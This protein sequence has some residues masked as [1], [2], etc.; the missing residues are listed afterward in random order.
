[1]AVFYGSRHRFTRPIQV[2]D[3]DSNVY[4]VFPL[5]QTT[6]EPPTGSKRYL[7]QGG[8]TFETLA[9]SFYNDA[10]KWYVLADANSQVFWPL[11][12]ESGV[13]V[14]VPPRSFAELN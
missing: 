4:S 8:D 5:Q 1:M 7:V 12:L 2:E 6:V 10:N 9:Y 13:E 14:I 3:G 11:D